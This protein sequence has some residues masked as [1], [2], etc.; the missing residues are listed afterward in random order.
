MQENRYEYDDGSM[1]LNYGDILGSTRTE[2]EKRE[3][4]IEFIMSQQY[5]I[6]ADLKLFGGK[7]VHAVT[8]EL[9]QLHEMETFSPLGA[10]NLTKKYMV[11]LLASLMFLT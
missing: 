8:S 11:D 4:V 6:K 9:E 2:E 7:G 1:L 3:K 5:S 10:N